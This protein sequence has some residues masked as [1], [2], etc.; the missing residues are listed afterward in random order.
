[1]K[2]R[3]KGVRE[4]DKESQ[5]GDQQAASICES[6]RNYRGQGEKTE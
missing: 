6:E 2:I 5:K 3:Q 1:M 4:R